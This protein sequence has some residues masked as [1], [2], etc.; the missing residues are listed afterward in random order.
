MDGEDKR[1][2]FDAVA[3]L[4]HVLNYARKTSGFTS[5]VYFQP[6]WPLRDINDIR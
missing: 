1:I 2:L 6:G 3:S 5:N 4:L